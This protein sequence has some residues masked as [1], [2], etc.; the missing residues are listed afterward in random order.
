VVGVDAVGALEGMDE[1]DVVGAVTVT[2]T[3]EVVVSPS[4]N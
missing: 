2:K 1:G 3:V 4:P